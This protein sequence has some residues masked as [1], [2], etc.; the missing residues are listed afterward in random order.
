MDLPQT[1]SREKFFGLPFSNGPGGTGIEVADHVDCA[2]ALLV[3]GE[4]GDAEIILRAERGKDAGE[5]RRLHLHLQA[6]GGAD[7][8][9]DVNV[10]ANRGLAV[11]SQ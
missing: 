2:E 7:R 4:R 5:F 11:A 1:S 8:L 6:E 9:G 10:V 3:D